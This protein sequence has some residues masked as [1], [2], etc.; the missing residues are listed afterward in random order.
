[1]SRVRPTT[2]LRRG[3]SSGQALYEF[4]IILPVFL[5]LLVSMLEFGFAFSHNLT[6]EYATREGARV[7]AALVDGGGGSGCPN[8]ANVDP[9]IIAAVERVLTSPGSQVTLANVS[10]INIWK[11]DGSGNPTPGQVNVWDYSPGGGPIPQGST[12]HLNFADPSYP[13]ADAWRPCTRRNA[14]P[15]P[16]S[17]GISLKYHYTFVTPLGGLMRLINL[18]ANW[19]GIDMSDK[20]VMA[21]NPSAPGS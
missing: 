15:S 19:T 17:I 21:M 20:T 14:L 2:R 4:A 13:S 3:D 7:G 12:T 16:D 5:I 11:D 8:A 10:E 1:M 9:L 18:N 6:L